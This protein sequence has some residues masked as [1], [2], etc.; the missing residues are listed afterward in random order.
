MKEKTIKYK[1]KNIDIYFTVDRCTHIAEC[2]RG[3]PEVFN[4]AR[5]PW[6]I[7]DADEPDK[8]AEVIL[9]CPTGAL[10]FKRKDGGTEETIPIK[11][12]ATIC[13]NGPLYLQGNLE[14]RN[15][16]D[17]LILKD[18]RIAL[19]RCGASQIMPLCDK[20]HTFT[21]F[22][23][24]KRFSQGK[25]QKNIDHGSIIITLMNDGPLHLQGPVE[26]QNPEGEIFFKGETITLCRC[27]QSQNMPFCDGSHIKAGFKTK[28][29]IV[30]YHITK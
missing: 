19:C 26:I 20:S 8:I 23:D 9:R 1:G 13:R 14:I 17:S 18:T 4:S 25:I 3:A 21:G 22:R 10:H 29:N 12:S 6:I 16:D 5:Q 7:T 15:F 27:G 2:I 28:K 30:L 24:K 11:N